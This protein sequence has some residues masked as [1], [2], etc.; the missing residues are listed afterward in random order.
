MSIPIRSG[1]AVPVRRAHAA[2][3]PQAKGVFFGLTHQHGPANW[4]GRYGRRGICSGDGMDGS[5]LRR[6]TRQR[7]AYW[8]RGAQLLLASDAIWIL[9]GSLIIVLAAM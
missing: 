7:D 3:N 6:Q 4:R 5:R 8:R 2:H 9:A 1:F